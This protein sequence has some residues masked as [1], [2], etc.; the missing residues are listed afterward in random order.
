M[1]AAARCP[2]ERGGTGAADALAGRPSQIQQELSTTLLHAARFL[3]E[4]EKCGNMQ[5]AQRSSVSILL[6]LLVAGIHSSDKLKLQYYVTKDNDS[7]PK[8]CNAMNI[9][10]NQ[11]KAFYQWLSE[12]HGYGL[13]SP[14]QSEHFQDPAVETRR[15][16][17]TIPFGLPT[18]RQPARGDTGLRSLFKT[19][20]GNIPQLGDDGRGRQRPWAYHSDSGGKDSPHGDVATQAALCARIFERKTKI[21]A[22]VRTGRVG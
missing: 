9:E 2:P 19:K 1:R 11:R 6:D 15:Q 8:I 20:L 17:R 16:C 12:Q 18:T 14:Q 22:H 3:Q 7:W 4:P 21:H 5:R 10:Y 13:I